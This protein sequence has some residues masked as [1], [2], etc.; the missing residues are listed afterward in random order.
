MD[1]AD[2]WNINVAGFWTAIDKQ[3]PQRRWRHATMG[4]YEEPID[5]AS[6]ALSAAQR[7]AVDAEVS[8]RCRDMNGEGCPNKAAIDVIARTGHLQELVRAFCAVE[9]QHF[10]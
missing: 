5:E 6:K 7:R 10:D 9:P 1:P 2:A 4:A 8:T 3:C